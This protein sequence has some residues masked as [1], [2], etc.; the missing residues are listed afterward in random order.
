MGGSQ[1][2]QK[3]QQ[4]KGSDLHVL[5]ERMVADPQT[6]T[7]ELLKLRNRVFAQKSAINKSQD[8]ALR[9]VLDSIGKTQKSEDSYQKLTKAIQARTNATRRKVYNNQ[10]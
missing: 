3:Q 1:S 7:P 8:Q 10:K 2:R 9:V 4:T 6:P 5:V